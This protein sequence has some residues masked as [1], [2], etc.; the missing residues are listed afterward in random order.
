MSKTIVIFRKFP[1]SEGGEIVALFPCE[2]WD[3]NPN[4]CA[5]YMHNG[6]HGG[7][8]IS[9]IKDTKRAK[10]EEYEPLKKELESLGYSLDVK[11][12]NH[13]SYNQVRYLRSNRR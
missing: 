3:S 10:Q 11:M 5:S 2:A 13:V 4:H 8:C 6:Q 9:L 7:A 12:K 1:L